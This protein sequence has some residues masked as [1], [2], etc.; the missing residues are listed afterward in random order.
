ME[1]IPLVNQH[2]TNTEAKKI[3]TLLI[4]HHQISLIL[5]E[6]QEV[7]SQKINLMLLKLKHSINQPQPLHLN[8]LIKK[9]KDYKNQPLILLVDLEDKQ[10]HQLNKNLMSIKIIISLMM[11][12]YL[13]DQPHLKSNPKSSSLNH[14]YHKYNHKLNTLNSPNHKFSHKYLHFI[15]FIISH[16][17]NNNSK[18]HNSKHHNLSINNLTQ[19][20]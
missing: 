7:T 14:K 12:Y 17:S 4:I 2:L 15:I 20:P 5:L 11:I 10:P 9:L 13:E 1:T 16:I 3:R 6:V 19:I 8:H 18:S